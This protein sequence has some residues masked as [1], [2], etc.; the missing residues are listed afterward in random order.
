MLL[1]D[2]QQ[3]HNHNETYMLDTDKL[4]ISSTVKMYGAVRKTLNYAAKN[5]WVHL[6]F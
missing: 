5:G 6:T 1:I 4:P 3:Q 2:Y